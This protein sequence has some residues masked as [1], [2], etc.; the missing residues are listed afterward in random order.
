MGIFDMKGIDYVAVRFRAAADQVQAGTGS[1]N[2]PVVLFDD[3]PPRTGWAEILALA[4]RLGGRVSL[5]PDDDG[6]R[7]RLH[8]L[9][10]ELLGEGGLGWSVRLLLIHASLTTEGREGWPLPVAKIL[11]PKYGY[12]PERAAGA[13]DR[14]VAVLRLFS[15]TLDEAQGR[16]DEYFLG[17]EPSALDVYAAAALGVVAPMPHELCPMLAPVRHAIETLDRSVRDAATDNLLAHRSRMFQRHLVLPVR[18]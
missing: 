12:A 17:R 7:V 15:R 8:G 5:V 14:A 16:G 3:E 18:L 11:A 1:H 10:Q 13:R 2:A 9:A 6:D 4:Q